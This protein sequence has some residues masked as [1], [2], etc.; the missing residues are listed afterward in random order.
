MCDSCGHLNAH[1]KV[2]CVGCPRWRDGKRPNIKLSVSGQALAIEATLT[3]V[4]AQGNWICHGCEAVNLGQKAR[5]RICQSWKGGRR[6]NMPTRCTPGPNCDSQE[7]WTCDGC[8]HTNGGAKLRCGSCQH[9]KDGRRLN[10]R[11]KHHN[12]F[13]TA[14][15]TIIQQKNV[16]HL[17][18]TPWQCAKCGQNNEAT[19]LRCRNCKSWKNSKHK[20]LSGARASFS[21]PPLESLAPEAVTPWVCNECNHFNAVNNT[22]CDSCQC[23]QDNEKI[24]HSHIKNEDSHPNP[25]EQKANRVDHSAVGLSVDAPGALPAHYYAQSP[26]VHNWQD[27]QQQLPWVCPRCSRE[28]LGSKARCG[29]CQKWKGWL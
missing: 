2:R 5:C 15:A 18:N 13:S 24:H 20:Q 19:K 29:G 4:A 12:D 25:H 21:A 17:S 7:P 11:A 26:E 22:R 3:D 9:W 23:W 16:H 10:M 27:A 8:G 1:N 6:Q 28:N 14:P